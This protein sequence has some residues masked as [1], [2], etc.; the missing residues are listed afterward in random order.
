MHLNGSSAQDCT[1]KAGRLQE[2]FCQIAQSLD[3]DVDSRLAGSRLLANSPAARNG[4]APEWS[5]APVILDRESWRILKDAACTMHG[6]MEAACRKFTRDPLFRLQFHLDPHLEERCTQTS[7][8]GMYLPLARVDLFFNQ[9]TGQYWFCETNTDGSAGFTANDC[10]TTAIT[11]SRTF[12]QFCH[13]HPSARP[14]MLKDAW[15]QTMLQLY[16]TWA[17]SHPD[18]AGSGEDSSTT[19]TPTADSTTVNPAVPAVALVD[20]RES[21]E[22]G[23]AQDFIST[24]NQMGIPARFADIRGLRLRQERDASSNAAGTKP[25]WRLYDPEGPIDLVWKRAVTGEIARKP[26]VGA[27]ALSAAI[28]GNHA[29]VIGGFSTWPPATKTL[30]AL[31]HHPSSKA[32]LT[33]EQQRFV[34]EHVPQTYSLNPNFLNRP[35]FDQGILTDKDRWIIKPADGYNAM[36][37]VAG[38]DVDQETWRNALTQACLTRGVVQ[39]YAPQY[40]A[41]VIPGILNPH[42][43]GHPQAPCQFPRHNTML[44]LFLFNG[45]FS[46]VFSRCGDSRVI[47]ESQGRLEQGCIFVDE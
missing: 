15:I 5:M 42:K 22:W 37:I 27:A 40:A 47:G 2:E 41:A 29:I 39:E 10:V 17:A 12:Q 33:P 30:F 19:G 44:G 9:E 32:W 43:T 8:V 1:L 28:Q 34:A 14:L 45:V 46:G 21:I 38:A 13:N 18:A 25:R 3:G 24:L 16:R 26:N 11:Q 31:L 4:M 7:Q 23:E 20:Y 6:I 36:G 35:G